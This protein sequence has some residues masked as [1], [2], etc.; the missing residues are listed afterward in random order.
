MQYSK[1]KI[2]RTIRDSFFFTKLLLKFFMC[3]LER[4]QPGFQDVIDCETLTYPQVINAIESFTEVKF[5][6]P[7]S[8]GPQ[9]MC[10]KNVA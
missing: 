3:L 6:N 10:A 8:F 9:F 7:F 5:L 4:G 2:N 1:I